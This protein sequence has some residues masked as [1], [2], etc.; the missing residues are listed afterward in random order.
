MGIVKF[1]FGLDPRTG[2]LVGGGLQIILGP[3]FF[4][5]GICSNWF[6]FGWPLWAGNSIC[7]VYF[8]I[9]LV[10]GLLL[11]CGSFLY[12]PSYVLIHQMASAIGTVLLIAYLIMTSWII[13]EFEQMTIEQLHKLRNYET[14]ILSIIALLGFLVCLILQVYLII[15]SRIFYRKLKT[16]EIKSGI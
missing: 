15:G 7:F 12:K 11:L 5:F 1:H 13:H 16:G 8:L 3:M 10:A 4:I 6:L 2:S 9:C 14:Y